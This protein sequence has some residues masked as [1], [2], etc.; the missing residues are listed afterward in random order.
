MTALRTCKYCGLQAINFDGLL[1]FMINDRSKYGRK[2]T[3]KLCH[4]VLQTGK[5]RGIATT[6]VG[7]HLKIGISKLKPKETV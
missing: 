4:T 1:L 6:I 2:N 7:P 5:N 3:C